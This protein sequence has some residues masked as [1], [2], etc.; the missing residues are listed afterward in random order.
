MATYIKTLKEDNG[1]ITYPQTVGGAVLLT[2]GSDLET[3]LAAKADASDVNGKIDIG[4]VIS[5][6]M[7]ANS[8]TTNAITNLNVTTAKLANGAVTGNGNSDTA[9]GSS[10][11]ALATIGTPNL[12]DSAV[13]SAKIA[14]GAVTGNAN[15]DT[16]VGTSK[17]AL[18]TI[19]TP[20][21][22]DSAVSS[23]KI[24]AGA[25]TGNANSDT[26][27]GTSKIA[28]ATIGTP[29]LRDTSVSTAKIANGAVT[30]VANTATSVGS[31]K[32]ALATVG[33]PN[34]RNDAVTYAKMNYTTYGRFA[35]NLSGSSYSQSYTA[36][37]SAV[38]KVPNQ[39]VTAVGA[40]YNTSTG[41]YTISQP[42]I[43]LITG[44]GRGATDSAQHGSVRIW[45]N[46]SNVAV[47]SGTGYATSSVK[48]TFNTTLSWVGHL[49]ANDTVQ[50]AITCSGSLTN[51]N[52]ATQQHLEG[53]CLFPD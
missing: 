40:T 10:K 3:T 5:S 42:G 47:G 18:T 36:G 44:G 25:I 1:D 45:V 28:L 35:G 16:A 4:N 17:I 46:G 37:T 53:V 11:I 21:L 12:R 29:N 38:A 41:A 48:T 2:G 9:V 20:N 14:A 34:L 13:A 26:A 19:G 31:A 49:A 30:G 32:L 43:W 15:S 51:S 22:R 7:T 8:V 23:A 39:V 52:S 50:L 24:A 33:T 27:V 6:D